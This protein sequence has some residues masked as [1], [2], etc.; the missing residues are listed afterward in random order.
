MHF[1]VYLMDAENHIRAG[2]PLLVGSDAEAID[3][4]KLLYCSC[5]DVFE[6]CEVWQGPERIYQTRNL[7]GSEETLAEVS[8][9]RQRL[10][11]SMEETLA[12]SFS[13]VRTSRKLLKEMDALK[14]RLGRTDR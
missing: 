14:K 11:A 4:A 9:R 3:M 10:V 1:R 8:E 2:H 7:N 6:K 13:C 5:D 12:A